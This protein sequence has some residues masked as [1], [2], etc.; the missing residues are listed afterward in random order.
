MNI[1]AGPSHEQATFRPP[2]EDLT[3]WDDVSDLFYW[4]YDRTQEPLVRRLSALRNFAKYLRDRRV[5]GHELGPA[6]VHL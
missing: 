3:E 4:I 2:P 5:R 6:D 1:D